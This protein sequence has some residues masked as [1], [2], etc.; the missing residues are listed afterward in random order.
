MY[1]PQKRNYGVS[2]KEPFLK[3]STQ[4]KNKKRNIIKGS[5][6]LGNVV[7]LSICGVVENF[8]WIHLRHMKLF[9]DL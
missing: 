3:F 7:E 1:G 4:V 2:F 8:F 6:R 9:K 5:D